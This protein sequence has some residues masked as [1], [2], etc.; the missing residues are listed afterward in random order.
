[1]DGRLLLGRTSNHSQTTNKE[2]LRLRERERLKRHALATARTSS[3]SSRWARGRHAA[4]VNS[5]VRSRRGTPQPS[6]APDPD[7][8]AEPVRVGTFGVEP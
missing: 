6:R 2:R 4:I 5:P 3:G 1:M 8:E 7:R